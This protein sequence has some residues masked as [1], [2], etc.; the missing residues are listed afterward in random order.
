[1]ATKRPVSLARW[2]AKAPRARLRTLEAIA[3][4]PGA[5]VAD[6][7]RLQAGGLR[8]CERFVGS[9]YDLAECELVW[10]TCGN[11]RWSNASIT[12]RGKNIL[13]KAQALAK[14]PRKR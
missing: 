11:V 3:E 1:M 10:L 9:I 2:V 7:A 4:S 6:I 8:Y 14:P 12:L 5:T 13:A